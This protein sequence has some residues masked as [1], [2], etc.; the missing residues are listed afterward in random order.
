MDDH[1]DINIFGA[2]VFKSARWRLF[3]RNWRILLVMTVGE[4]QCVIFD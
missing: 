2:V 4:V 1:T 3:F